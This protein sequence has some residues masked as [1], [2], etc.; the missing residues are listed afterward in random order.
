MS[1]GQARGTIVFL[2]LYFL[3]GCFGVYL[4][5]RNGTIR[6]RPGSDIE[7]VVFA[8]WLL[9]PVLLFCAALDY[10]YDLGRRHQ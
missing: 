8:A 7:A 9:W 5:A 6:E 10:C 2:V 3:V 4:G 1:D